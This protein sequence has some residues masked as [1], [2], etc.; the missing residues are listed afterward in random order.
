MKKQFIVSKYIMADSAKE[1]MRKSKH[2]PIHECYIHNSWFEKAVNFEFA[3][4]KVRQP[5]F[6]KK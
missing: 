4:P 5:G 1:A 6:N 2:I 3:P